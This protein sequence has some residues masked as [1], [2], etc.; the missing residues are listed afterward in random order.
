M[1]SSVVNVLELTT[2]RVSAASIS[3]VA[4]HMSAPSTLDTNRNVSAR[5]ENGNRASYA[6]AGPRSEPPMPIF[7][8]FFMRLPVNPRQRPSRTASAKSAIF[9][10]TFCTSGTTFWPPSSTS[11]PSWRTQGR[12]QDGAVLGHVYVL[13]RKHRFYAFV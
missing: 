3:A 11:V 4:S 8:M 12:V 7:T 1:V 6:I 5:S 2:K 13:A 10:R 9:P